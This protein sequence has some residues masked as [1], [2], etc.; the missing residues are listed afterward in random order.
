MMCKKSKR[1]FLECYHL[2]GLVRDV[3]LILWHAF[4]HSYTNNLILKEKT[5]FK[6]TMILT[7]LEVNE[8][9]LNIWENFHQG[10]LTEKCCFSFAWIYT[11][12]II[13]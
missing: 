3:V 11:M 5:G 9:E 7:W 4:S 6:I 10:R 12:I 8:R 2:S 13:F 1:N